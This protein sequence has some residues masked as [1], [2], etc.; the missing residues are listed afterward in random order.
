MDSFEWNKIAGA[1]LF[2]LLVTFGLGAFSGIIFSTDVPK[3]PGYVI[4]VTEQPA[5]GEAKPAAAPQ[6]IAVLLASADPKA[7]EATAKKCAACHTFGQGESP[8]VGPNL[9]GVVDRPIASTQF[10]YS[11]AMKKHAEEAKTWTFDNLNAFIHD[12]KGVVPGTKMAFAGLKDD[13]ERANVIAYLRTLSPSPVP[14]PTPPAAAPAAGAAAPAEAGAAAPAQG[15]AAPVNTAPAGSAGSAPT[16]QSNQEGGT[17]SQIQQ[18]KGTLGPLQSTTADQQG[19]VPQVAPIEQPH[20]E[21]PAGEPAAGQAAAPAQAPTPGQAQSQATKGP[22]SQGQATETAKPPASP[23]PQQVAPSEPTAAPAGQAPAAPAGQ[24]AQTAPPA[25]ATAA[26]APAMPAAPAATPAAPT[27]SAPAAP[28][29]AA[30]APAAPA[31]ST[32]PAPAPS[33]LPAPAPAAPQKS[34]EATTSAQILMASTQAPAA[35]GSAGSS[36]FSTAVATASVANG[37]NVAKKC[38]ICHDL[39]KGAANRVGPHLWG[40]V[41]RPVASVPDFP[42]SDAMKAFS[43]GG[44]KTW[45]VDLLGT[46]LENPKAVVPGTKMAFPGIPDVNQRA[47]LVAFLRT[48]SDNPPAPANP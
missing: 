39:T 28:A 15:A 10:Q 19:A 18:P 35:A 30:P 11:D 44:K 13:Q 48:L 41:D 9:Y 22:A 31:P 46:Y 24:P 20:P 33:T 38:Q 40:I 29:T 17:S 1:V 34:G 8:K 26:P 45:T 16:A 5:G 36:E 42:Y 47:Q 27:T 23:A 14:L 32:P 12:P 25:P 43:E 4:A 6:P 37:Q 21:P 3:S 7:G 2:A